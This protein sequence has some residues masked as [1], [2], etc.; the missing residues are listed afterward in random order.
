MAL[1]IAANN[2]P[3]W[4]ASKFGSPT[5]LICFTTQKGCSIFKVIYVERYIVEAKILTINNCTLPLSRTTI[6]ELSMIVFRRCAI[7][8]TV[9]SANCFLTVSWTS[10]SVTVSTELVASS[11]IQKKTNM[12][13]SHPR[14]IEKDSTIS[15]I[16]G[17]RSTARAMHISWRWPADKL[18]PYSNISSW[19]PVTD[20]TISHPTP[21]LPIPR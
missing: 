1:R 13:R 14:K 4:R 16:L 2:P 19:R 15:N 20:I 17:L 8:I 9:Q 11:Y 6:R 3:L 21:A 7:V 10:W 18:A 12:K 5:S